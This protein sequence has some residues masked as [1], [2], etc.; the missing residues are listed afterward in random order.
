ML[1]EDDW[2]SE[3][4][5][6]I[7]RA[8]MSLHGRELTVNG[9][10]IAVHL[11]GTMSDAGEWRLLV[12]HLYLIWRQYVWSDN[13]LE[14]A[15]EIVRASQLR[16]AMTAAADLQR[17]AS[18]TSPEN[19]MVMLREAQQHLEV[20]AGRTSD[21]NGPV[22]GQ[23]MLAQAMDIFNE[24]ADPVAASDLLT[25]PWKDM[26]KMVKP[27]RAGQVVFIGARPSTG[28][29]AFMMNLAYAWLR[30]R[31]PGLIV[32]LEMSKAALGERVIKMHCTPAEAAAL[33][34][35]EDGTLSAE[36]AMA[37]TKRAGELTLDF[38][39]LPI[40]VDDRANQ[41]V[42]DIA[43]A[44]ERVQQQQNLRWVMI[45]YLQLIRSGL[46]K[47]N[48]SP[49]EELAHTS[50]ALLALAKQYKVTVIVLS[51]LTRDVER[52]SPRRPQLHN[53]YGSGMVEAAG[54]L[55]LTLYWPARYGKT[56]CKNAGYPDPEYWPG[57]MEIGM[58]KQRGGLGMGRCALWYDG[59]RTLFSDLNYKQ[60][61][62]LQEMQ[63][64]RDT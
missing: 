19:A 53:M 4:N 8:V 16:K 14:Y 17:R 49:A 58:L 30:E 23:K 9:N 33:G 55:I 48:A 52:E 42:A 31:H 28:K 61:E 44:I 21:A 34:A 62:A 37:S 11:Q 47:R 39:D 40:T 35:L 29:T 6:V 3:E 54:Q 41:S 36:D 7:W 10:S 5:R 38:Y 43:A 63:G 2:Y 18:I 24:L 64:R 15:A 12:S 60:Q 22:S 27:L 59:P 13:A 56:E 26:R 45:D 1:K 25:M 32:S 20:I 51:Q 46:G 50:Y 57:F